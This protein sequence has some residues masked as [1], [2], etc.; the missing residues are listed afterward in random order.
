MVVEFL[1]L[2]GR[3]QTLVVVDVRWSAGKAPLLLLLGA[4]FRH[5]PER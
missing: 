5:Q 2:M 3:A 1:V 4:R